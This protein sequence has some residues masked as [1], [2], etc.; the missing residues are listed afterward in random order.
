VNAYDR[1]MK[2]SSAPYF[3]EKIRNANPISEILVERGIEL[4]TAASGR[5]CLCQFP[6]HCDTKPSFSISADGRLEHDGVLFRRKGSKFWWMCYRDRDG[7]RRRESTFTEDW[8]EANK[9]LRER[10]QARDGNIL[11]VVRKG[12]N[13]TF[14]EWTDFFLENYSKPPVREP[15]THEANLRATNHLKKSFVTCR[16]GDVTADEIEH[17]LRDRLRQR[18][19]FKTSSGYLERGRLKP[20]TVHQELR[21]LRRMLNVAV[22]KK[23]LASNPCSTVEFPVAVKGLFRPHYVSWSEQQKIEFHAPAHLRNVVRIIADP[24]LRVYKE[25]LPMK[26]EQVD[27]A[28]A[29]AWI[30]DSKTPS[31]ISELPLSEF[32]LEAFRNQIAIA[33]RGEFLFPSDQTP[34]KPVK[35]AKTAWRNTLRRAGIRYFR[36]YDLRSTYATRLSAGGVTDEW[37]TQMLRQ[38]DAQVF[39]KYSQMKLQMKREALEKL[40]RRANEMTTPVCQNSPVNGGFGTVLTQ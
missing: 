30:P 21:V 26:K 38:G 12:E 5:M 23:L 16:L 20:T 36:I 35:S 31:G 9:K 34:T 33:G 25:L 4:Q 39:K 15:K 29:V 1:S 8:T 7:T 19:R 22:R 18:V 32:A 14:G 40:N 17:Y 2:N 11:Q 10:L 6:D 3:T 37:V 27:F 13:L 24:G 28:N